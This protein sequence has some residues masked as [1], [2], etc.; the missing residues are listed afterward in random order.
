MIN[1]LCT[2]DPVEQILDKYS[3]M[4][5]RIA[6]SATNNVHHAEDIMQDVFLR[7]V[8]KGPCFDSEEHEKAWFI[9][10]TVNCSKD[11]LQSAWLRKIKGLDREIAV[12]FNEKSEVYHAVMQLPRDMRTVIYLHYYEDY[13]IHEIAELLKRSDSYVKSILH[14]ARKK[15]KTFLEENE[16]VNF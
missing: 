10:V 7:Y 12:T 16:D 3:S 4:V 1:N 6:L 9:R 5:F 15:L 14:R 11:L 2:N 8:N 13:K